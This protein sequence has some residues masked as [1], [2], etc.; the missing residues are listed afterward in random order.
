MAKTTKQPIELGNTIRDIVTGFTGIATSK[1]IYLN[2]CVQFSV[3]PK[4]GKD[5]KLPEATY[6]D[7]EQ[8]EW[9]DNG[10]VVKPKPGGGD[11]MDTPKR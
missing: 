5:G 4:M 7:Q 9:V 6:I 10:I 8:L 11:M 1:V 2:G 3:K